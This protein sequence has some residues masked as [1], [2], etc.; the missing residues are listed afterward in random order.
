MPLELVVHLVIDD[1]HLGRVQPKERWAE[2]AQAGA[3][4]G[5]V[6]GEAVGAKGN[7]LAISD[8]GTKIFINIKHY[9]MYVF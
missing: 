3:D 4:P 8:R 9:V 5:G 7:H 6:A 2:L 1:A